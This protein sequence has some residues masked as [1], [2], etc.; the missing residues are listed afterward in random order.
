MS[1]PSLYGAVDLSSLARPAQPPRSA[2]GGAAGAPGG[3]GGSTGIVVDV[4]EE[5][6]GDVVARSQ[7][8]P[9]L[10]AVLS[11]RTPD[12]AS[13]RRELEIVVR[14]QA[15]RL[16]LGLVDGDS[17][18]RIAQALQ[19]EQ[20][21]TVVA[22]LGGQPMPLFAGMV[23]AEQLRPVI[24]E[25]MRM[26]EQS[27]LT[28]QLPVEDDEAGAEPPE[29]ELPP[30]HAEGVAAIERGDFDAAAEAYRKALAQNPADAEATAALAQ[31]E[32]ARR[33]SPVTDPAATIAAGDAEGASLAE[34]LLAADVE[35]AAGRAKEAF[36]RILRVI[37]VSAGDDKE[38]AR[39]RLVEL[40]EI[41]G[42][43]DPEV[44]AARRSLASALY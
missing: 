34:V 3:A 14:E 42:A 32:L 25:L 9:V 43:A 4:T 21:P 37:R 20:V 16:Q 8:L 40:F 29:P 12:S 26:A 19:V 27:G 38:S 24:A 36:D 18:P 15:G 6:F 1:Q 41:R 5:T 35:F 17:Q 7:E 22:V 11:D 13:L 30:L 44:V 31:V 28:G 23:G 39:V 10:L 2:P 33:V